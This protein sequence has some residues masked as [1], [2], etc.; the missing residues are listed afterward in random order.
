MEISDNGKPV[1][2]QGRKVMGLR[3]SL[4]SYDCQTAEEIL[5]FNFIEKAWAPSKKSP[6]F[7]LPLLGSEG[8]M[9]WKD[10]ELFSIEKY[11]THPYCA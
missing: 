5:A 10:S 8:R 3:L 6:R 2:R 7:F 4:D 9:V 11:I 1:E